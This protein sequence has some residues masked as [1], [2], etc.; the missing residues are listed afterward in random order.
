MGIAC[1]HA[2]K[3]WKAMQGALPISVAFEVGFMGY[4]QADSKQGHSMQAVTQAIPQHL[5]VFKYSTLRPVDSRRVRGGVT[6][7]WTQPRGILFLG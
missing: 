3:E 4:D 7:T 5:F 6:Q 2:L 1:G